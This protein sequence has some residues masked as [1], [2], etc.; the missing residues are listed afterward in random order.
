[1]S[2]NEAFQAFAGARYLNLETVRKNG[3]AVRTPVWF[4]AAPNDPGKLYTYTLASAG[5]V[6]RIRNNP[7]VRIAPCDW[8]GNPLG[9]WVAARA[10]I[11]SPEEAARGARLLNRK[12]V[13]WRQLLNFFA[14]IHRRK[15]A[16]IVIRPA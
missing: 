9:E 3:A 6:K 14:L 15:R 8:R 16:G 2:T 5:K 4:A 13:P 1:M 7:R 12:F 10:E 11:A